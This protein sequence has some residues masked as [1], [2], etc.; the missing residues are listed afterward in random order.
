[1]ARL[2]NHR[3]TVELKHGTGDPILGHLPVAVLVNHNTASASEIVAGA[4]RDQVSAK[5]VGTQPYGKG[6]VQGYVEMPN[7]GWAKITTHWWHTPKDTSVSPGGLT[8]DITVQSERCKGCTKLDDGVL[9][10]I[11]SLAK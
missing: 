10:A 7:G 3:G 8:P 5:L 2:D 6:L 4:L 9:A 11:G 1:M